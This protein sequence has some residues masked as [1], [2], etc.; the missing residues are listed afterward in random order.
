MC[1]IPL[2]FESFVSL[3]IF[4]PPLLPRC[5]SVSLRHRTR[6]HIITEAYQSPGVR[7]LNAHIPGLR[8][9]PSSVLEDDLHRC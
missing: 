9:F 5:S 1:V 4:L 2:Y 6:N 3:F 7:G 8:R